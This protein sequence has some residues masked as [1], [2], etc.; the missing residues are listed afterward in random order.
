MNALIHPL[1]FS[2]SGPLG[3]AVNHGPAQESPTELGVKGFKKV[4]T[5]PENRRS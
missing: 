3:D 2:T 5:G 1:G 4:Q